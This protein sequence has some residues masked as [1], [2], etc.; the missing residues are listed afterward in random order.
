M[1]IVDGIETLR[2]FKKINNEIKQEMT[3][4]HIEKVLT[5]TVNENTNKPFGTTVLPDMYFTSTNNTVRRGYFMDTVLKSNLDNYF[6]KGVMKKWDAVMLITGMEGSGKSTAAMGIAKYCD[7]TFPGEPLNDGTTRRTCDRIVFTQKEFEDAV[8]KAK[9]GQ[10][11]VWDEMVLG[12]LAQDAATE[13]QKALI[14]LMTTI[15]KKRLFLFFIIPSIFMLRMYFAVQRARALI[16]FFSPDGV[17]RG[18]FKF[19]S[20]DSKTVLYARGKKEFNMG[21]ANSDY[22]GQS[23]DLTGLFFDDNEYQKKKDD[24]I[25]KISAEK[26]PK[27][28]E[29]KF[30][31][32]KAQRDILLYY[33]YNIHRQD[34]AEW[35]LRRYSEWIYSCF[36]DR[37]KITSASLKSAFKNALKSLGVEEELWDMT[38]DK[39]KKE[40]DDFF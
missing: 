10:A 23:T 39:N 15:R 19:F 3:N 33:I 21:A 16:H 25:K 24:A 22:I 40:K 7:P 29:K 4:E 28:K 20:Y 12:G 26:D 6:I 18:Q 30:M 27:K 31:A 34:S 32:T 2:T 35:N 8:H 37:L 36:G 5:T 13:A 1:A 14:K 17:S 9:P 38:L 11:I